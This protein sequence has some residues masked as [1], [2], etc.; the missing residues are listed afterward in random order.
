MYFFLSSIICSI[1]VGLSCML[2][3][4][5]AKT[6]TEGSFGAGSLDVLSMGCLG[7]LHT[8]AHS[9]LTHRCTAQ[10]LSRRA[11]RHRHGDCDGST[12]VFW[13]SRVKCDWK[14][15]TGTETQKYCGG[16]GSE[17]SG[18]GQEWCWKRVWEKHRNTSVLHWYLNPASQFKSWSLV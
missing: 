4:M 18:G 13:T 11:Q 5:D 9:F 14:R 2:C 6:L 17:C 12:P 16:D 1:S 3:I 15:R 7:P 10:R 8:T